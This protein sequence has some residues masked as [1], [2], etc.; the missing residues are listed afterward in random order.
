ML[1][2]TDIRRRFI[3]FFVKTHG[4]TFVPSSPVVPHDDPTLLFANAG[5]N[6]FKPYFLGTEQPP[7]P[8]AANTQKCIRAGGKHND[9][10]DVGHDTYHHTFFEMLGNWSFGDYFKTQAIDW[11]W[12]LLTDLWKIDPTRLHATYFGGD[13]AHGLD[14]DEEARQ[15]W[16]KHLPAD[17]VH[18]GNMKDNFWEMGD[19]GPCGPCS[20][21]HYDRTPHK[22]GAKLVN[23]GTSDVIEIWNLVFIQFNRASDG[24]LSPLPNKHVDTGMG[25]ERICAVLQGKPSNYDTDVFMP[26]FDAIQKI[27]GTRA[28]QGDLQDPIDIAYRV[29][30]DHARCLTFA[31]TDGAVPGNEGRG[32]VLRRI[33]RRAVRYGRQ[34]FGMAQPFLHELVPM[35]TESMG[36]AFAELK[37]NPQHVID[38]IKDEEHSFARTLD[39]GIELFNEAADR[40][41][42]DALAKKW[43]GKLKSITWYPNAGKGEAKVSFELEG[44]NTDSVAGESLESLIKQFRLNGLKISAADAFKLHDTYGFPLDLTQLMAAERGMTVDVE[45]FNTLMEQARAQSRSGGAAADV[46]ASLIDFVQQNE[47]PA[48]KFIGY[49]NLV[50][51]GAKIFAKLMLIGETYKQVPR[52]ELGMPA[53]LVVD[54]TPFYA[55]QGG[56]VGDTGYI[57]SHNGAVFKVTDTLK[58]GDIFFHLGVLESGNIHK[59][60]MPFDPAD[61]VMLEVDADRRAKIMV[62]H[63]VTHVMNHKLR[64]VMGDHI[65]QRGS[66]VDDE[67]TRFDFSHNQSLPPEDVERV[68]Q[69]VNADIAKDLPVHAEQVPQEKALKIHGLRAVFGEKYPPVVRVVTIGPTAHE[70]LK[71]PANAKW[72]E[73]SVEFCGGTHVASTGQIGAFTVVSEEAVA[74]GVRRVIGLTGKAAHDA[75]AAGKTLLAMLD[76]LPKTDADRMARGLAELNQQIGEQTIPLVIRAK[77][78]DGIEQLQKQVKD[79]Q[80]QAAKQAAGAAV[81]QARAIAEQAGDAAIIVAE[82]PGADAEALRSGMDVIR[83]M[84][85]DAAILLGASSGEDKVAFT[86][87]VPKELIAGGLKAGDW[88]RDVAKVAGGG[89]GGRPDA[90][91]AGGKDPAKLAEALQVARDF[92]QSKI[93][94]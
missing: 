37:K 86:A 16:L 56:Q 68:E 19:S 17:H 30:A 72:Y 39:R 61:G 24:K 41:I 73:S 1:T 11:A 4:H 45:G 40:A 7:Y 52:L 32:Y 54:Q 26:L 64:A 85:P 84:K 57:R 14:V 22:T 25:F 6:Q 34:T 59:K 10:E 18:P 89:G 79:Q 90:A 31:L 65:A 33:L 35:I 76:S 21:I 42:G 2:S 27:T 9:L 60:H 51:D 69:M 3:D 44:G 58:V 36:D 63:T 94:G 66:L 91:Q 87:S 80:K 78:R 92:A 62:N 43:S 8:R 53:A 74:K 13:P 49:K 23:G 88:V 81:D 47:M 28:Y 48:T 20:E 50:I 82:L 12:Q 46:K 55:E 71:D 93:G 70:M 83:K 75:T 29:I 15:L 38:I 77:L 5:M 67:K